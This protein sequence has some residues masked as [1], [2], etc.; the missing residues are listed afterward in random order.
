M[1]NPPVKPIKSKALAQ[2][3]RPLHDGM[4]LARFDFPHPMPRMDVQMTVPF[5]VMLSHN[6][7][8]ERWPRSSTPRHAPDHPRPVHERSRRFPIHP[9]PKRVGGMPN[10]RFFNDERASSAEKSHQPGELGAIELLR[11]A[12]QFLRRP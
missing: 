7:R 1:F 8:Y 6:R 10:R 9:S 12:K 11:L 5:K 3:N 2:A 4:L